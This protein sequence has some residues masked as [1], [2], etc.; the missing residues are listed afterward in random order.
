MHS[1]TSTC[2]TRRGNRGIKQATEHRAASQA[3]CQTPPQAAQFLGSVTLNIAII[4][5]QPPQP[6]RW[7]KPPRQPLQQRPGRR[8]AALPHG[9]LPAWE[10]LAPAR[11]HA[12]PRTWVSAPSE[13]VRQP[14]MP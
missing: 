14:R 4:S 8:A 13:G 3:G 6:H 11:L 5:P 7:L 9:R 10:G 2:L 12:E 1:V